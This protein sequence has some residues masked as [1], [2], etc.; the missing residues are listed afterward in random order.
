MDLLTVQNLT[1]TYPNRAAPALRDVSFSLRA[2]DFVVLCGRSG[3]G[4]TTLLRQLKP[5][6]APHGTR[7]G[8]VLWAGEAL[9]ARAPKQT[10]AEI[11]FVQQD[12][13]D[14][15]VTDT[16]WHELAFGAE[17]LGMNP[18]TIRRRVAETAAFF[19]IEDL[20]G[21]RTAD[22]SGGQAQLLNLAAAMVLQPKLLLLDEPTA[23]LDPVAADAFFSALKKVNREL[24]IAVLMTEHRLETALTLATSAAV[25]ED[26]TMLCCGDV[27]AV[28]ETLRARRDPLFFSMPAAMQL[29]CSLDAEPPCPVSVG[30]G[31]AFLSDFIKAHPACPVPQRPSAPGGEDAVTV[32][33]LHFSYDT[34]PV[35]RDLSFTA[36]TGTLTCILGGNGAGKSTLLSLL[37]GQLS[38]ARGTL[39]CT[40]R[41]GLLPQQMQTLFIKKTLWSDLCAVEA[42]AGKPQADRE[43]AVRDVLR[44]CR[45]EG[46]EDSHPFD[47]SGGEMQRAALAK[48][49]L[50]SPDVLLLD[51]PT[52]GFDT[53]FKRRFASILET[54]KA[55]GVCIVMVSHDVEF[56][57]RYAD[58]CALL[59]DGALVGNGPPQA[60]FSGNRFYTTQAARISHGLLADVITTPQLISAAG[61][62]APVW[63]ED[64]G[65][66]SVPQTASSLPAAAKPLARWRRVGAAL[67]AAAAAVLFVLLARTFPAA[68]GQDLSAFTTLTP[69]QWKLGGAFFFSLF[70]LALFT[71]RKQPN[72]VP[73][74]RQP[75]GL[76]TWLGV[77][78][79][80]CAV[81]PVLWFGTT[82]LPA[83]QYYLTALAVLLLAMLPFF[84]VF[85]GRKPRARELALL[86]ALCAVTTAGRAA[87][88][89]LPQC[90]P[91]L[92]MTVLAGVALGGE[93]GFLVGAV[94][95]LVSN[96]L[97]SQGAWTPWQMFAMGLVGFLAGLLA[98]LGLLR[99]S[100]GSLCVFGAAAAIV[101]Y[102]GIM[103]PA[104]ALIWG[105]EAL[106]R[107]ILLTYYAAG[108]PMDCVHAAA[109]ALFLWFLSPTVLDT[110]QRVKE[111]YGVF[112]PGTNE[113]N[114]G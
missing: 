98:R 112:E 91:V 56:C 87:F 74:G 33:E 80:V 15:L 79:C 66:A 102:G 53:A 48:A 30:E 94:T 52:K 113:V 26:G 25:L 97:F 14:Q 28:G 32:D 17:S 9:S 89:M 22:L 71:A 96:L 78:F 36:K 70:A 1:F 104:A 88:F 68:G 93:S 51:E 40:G 45:L 85:E 64:D 101:I 4:K 11:A 58:T 106:N 100:R 6:L 92:A 12:P 73:R 39:R 42:L 61:G 107:E 65:A 35:L 50:A 75:L 49:L 60:F 99:R 41:V 46:L 105:G 19:G 2:G 81:P 34:L 72:S 55:R 76:R 47:L 31:R 63:E 29:W 7:D 57:A 20:I 23:Q 114:E 10:A 109:T 90:K 59:F 86:A 16:V 27:T 43:T 37:A 8:R 103:N 62:A 77:G 108:F 110:L 3:S 67:S 82:L 44:L 13:Q 84:L 21:R 38:P 95:M 18:E 69:A 54:L 5:T 83:K 24:G 111:K